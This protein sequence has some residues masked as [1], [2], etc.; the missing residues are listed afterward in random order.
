MNFAV[1]IWSHLALEIGKD[2]LH[3]LFAVTWMWR[4]SF[5]ST[6]LSP[7]SSPFPLCNRNRS[8]LLT[9]FLS[10][11][12]LPRA[13]LTSKTIK[14]NK[15]LRFLVVLLKIRLIGNVN[16]MK[17]SNLNY[18]SLAIGKNWELFHLILERIYICF[19]FETLISSSHPFR[20][21]NNYPR[22]VRTWAYNYLSLDHHHH[23]RFIRPQDVFTQNSIQ[24]S[25]I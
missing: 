10:Y 18:W 6:P 25:Q 22:H 15:N 20:N 21:F 2:K 8:Y 17:Q 13:P 7:F 11:S 5:P 23:I 1:N 19:S 14:I 24:R 9:P 16:Y 4:T 3:R 12:S